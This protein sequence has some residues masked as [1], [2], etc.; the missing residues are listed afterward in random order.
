MALEHLQTAKMIKLASGRHRHL[1]G[2]D[3]ETQSDVA[4][5][6]TLAKQKMCSSAELVRSVTKTEFPDYELLGAFSVFWLDD[7]MRGKAR[8]APH[9]S[10]SECGLGCLNRLAHVFNVDADQLALEFQG[11]LRL[12]QTAK[13][14][15]PELS[16]ASAWACTLRETAKRAKK[17]RADFSIQ[18]LAS[19]SVAQC[20]A[21]FV[22]G[23]SLNEHNRRHFHRKGAFF[24]Q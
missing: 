19:N 24:S 21:T 2:T 18:H 8:R 16:A 3:T 14:R 9:T 13:S 17:K 7:S 1:G 22:G 10:L 4:E 20:G 6:L 15:K 12:A 23:A 5:A 11:H